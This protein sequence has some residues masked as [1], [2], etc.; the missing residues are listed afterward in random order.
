MEEDLVGGWRL[1]FD[2]LDAAG[3]DPLPNLASNETDKHDEEPHAHI[4]A[5]DGH[6]QKCF[7]DG[8]P[9]VFVQALDLH[10]AKRTIKEALE[11]KHE[12]CCEE[13]DEVGEDL[14]PTSARV[15]RKLG[16]GAP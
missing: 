2:E 1:L 8:E 3:P 4:V 12:G 15:L 13:E 9:G 10:G 6:G 11:S 16:R 5:E 7:G 14:L